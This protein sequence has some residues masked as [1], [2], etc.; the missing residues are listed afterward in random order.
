MSFGFVL[1]KVFCY[2]V[3]Y[4]TNIF[5]QFHVLFRSQPTLTHHIMLFSQGPKYNKIYLYSHNTVQYSKTCFPAINQIL[6]HTY[7]ILLNPFKQSISD[8]TFSYKFGL[9]QL[10]KHRAVNFWVNPVILFITDTLTCM[11]YLC[12]YIVMIRNKNV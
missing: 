8:E 1:N 2:D 11:I 7:L 9:Q 3:C 6:L 5:I 4:V 10:I 12:R